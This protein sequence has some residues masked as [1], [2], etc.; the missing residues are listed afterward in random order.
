ME[1]VTMV[2]Q[3]GGKTQ[4]STVG[5]L[6]V[7]HGTRNT[8]GQN[9]VRQLFSQ[10]TNE[11]A[12]YSLPGH[13]S[14]LA[15]LELAQPDIPTAVE[16]LH[17][18]G[19]V[20]L[21]VVPVLLFTAGHAERDI[22]QAVQVECERRG[23]RILRQSSSLGCDSHILELSA[24]RFRDA[25]RA[26]VQWD[27]TAEN[28]SNCPSRSRP[29]CSATV[30]GCSACVTDSSATMQS[31]QNCPPFDFAKSVPKRSS[32]ELSPPL[33]SP[34]QIGLAMIGRGSNSDTATNAM[35]R[36]AELRTQMTPTAWSTTGF[37]HAQRPT[38][39]EAL[40]GLA[41][42]GLPY[43]VVQPHLLFEGELVEELR[44]EIAYRQTFTNSQ[45]WIIAET[46]GANAQLAEALCRLVVDLK[47]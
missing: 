27:A 36:F 17:R 37:I 16:Q 35:L 46:L 8:A 44:R 32:A 10:M 34:D 30:P 13:A 25:L 24:D 4:D 2:D 18:R 5:Y 29:A 31:A 45:H 19:V 40:D 23:M 42:T 6:I 12:H 43:L 26:A 7:G 22:P 3:C 41:A 14:A 1:P 38:V 9:Q 33:P 20:D 47:V 11:M 21:V 15:F 39:D 28:L